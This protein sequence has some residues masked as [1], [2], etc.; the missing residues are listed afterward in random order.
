MRPHRTATSRART[1]WRSASHPTAPTRPTSGIVQ[2]PV[3]ARAALTTYQADPGEASQAFLS[4][5]YGKLRDWHAFLRARDVG[6]QGLAA[7]VYPWE[8]GLDN[9]PIEASAQDGVLYVLVSK[10]ADVHGKRR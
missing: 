6:G 3:H 2:P 5:M 10:A 4:E 7:I 9:T 8:S 1:F